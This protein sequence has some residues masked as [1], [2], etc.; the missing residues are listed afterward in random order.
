MKLKE[1]TKIA[2]M[3]ALCVVLRYAF[4]G[5]PNIQPVSA[6]FF[7]LVIYESLSFSLLVMATSVLVSSFLLGFGPW[8]LFQILSFSVIIIIW[9]LSYK[10]LNIYFRTLLVFC[11][12]FFYGIVIDS[13]TAAF[14]NMPWWS[15]VTAGLVFNFAHAFSTLVFYPM[16]EP[17]FRRLFYEKN[18]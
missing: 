16:L 5:L 18:T 3:S 11:L 9:N 12:T 15:Y 2:I 8:V 7:L 1:I 14:F 17:I 6:I 13:I 10:V 4:S